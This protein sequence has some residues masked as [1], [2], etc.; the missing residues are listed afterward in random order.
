MNILDE[1]VIES[2][3]QLL[4]RW[5]ISVRQ[6]GQEV[7][8]KGI[9]DDEIIPFLLTFRGS[10]FFTRDLGFFERGLCHRRYCLVCMAV[11][12]NESAN[13]VRRLLVHP[14]F[15]SQAKR[16]GT[17]LRISSRRLQVWRLNA[18]KEEPLEWSL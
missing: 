2:Q 10:T 4:Q 17:V 13:F 16:M 12:K 6:I 1:N 5:R 15:D 7:S 11:D 3:Y 8:R 9:Q 18:E 14:E